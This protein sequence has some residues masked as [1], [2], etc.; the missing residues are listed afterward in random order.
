MK[1]FTKK[2]IAITL[3]AFIFSTT[4]IAQPAK[5]C[6]AILAANAGSPSG[7]Y[8]ID[9]DGNGPIP[10]MNCYC[11]MTTDGGGWTLVL[12]YNHLSGTTPILKVRIDS[13]PVLGSS[14]LGVDESNSIYW[15]HTDTSIMNALVFDQIRFYG[16]TSNHNRV[17]DFKTTHAGTISYFKKGLGSTAGIK[18]DFTPFPNHTTNLPGAIDMTVTDQG[19]QAM[20]N[21]PLWT[22]STYHWYLD[23][24]PVGGCGGVRWEMDDFTC[25]LPST[26]HQIWVKQTNGASIKTNESNIHFNVSPNPFNSTSTLSLTG[27]SQDKTQNLSVSF[28]NLLGEEIIIQHSNSPNS[29]IINRDGIPNGIY[30]CQLKYNNEILAIKKVIIQ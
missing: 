16:I 12:N 10:T 2:I 13:L 23:G 27:I 20:T 22:G 21:F 19:N 30:F 6:S 15:G 1:N 3:L 9:P 26:I 5:S 29:I 11:D 17:M 18:T 24:S 28:Y 14:N 4:L 25:N 7:V 8:P